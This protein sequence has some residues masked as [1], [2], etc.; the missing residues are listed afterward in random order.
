[1]YPI[2][3]HF[4]AAQMI[5]QIGLAFIV[6]IKGLPAERYI[7]YVMELTG[8]TA[9]A[10]MLPAVR[11]YRRDQT[12]RQAGG[13]APLQGRKQKLWEFLLLLVIGAGLSQY[14]NMILGMLRSFFVSSDYFDTMNAIIYG[15]DVWKQ[16]F[17]MGIV[18]PVAEEMIFRWLI[19]LRLRDYLRLPAA[20]LLSGALFGIYHGDVMQGLYAAILGAVFAWFLEAT[21]NLLSC[22]LLHIGANT[23]GIVF[24]AYGMSWLTIGNGQLLWIL[25]GI[26]LFSL[27]A[28]IPYFQRKYAGDRRRMV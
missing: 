12:A 28:G 26:L 13:L 20:M 16:V 10:V 23:W 3:I 7:H 19:F 5:S 15:K 9:L 2:G 17:W 4:L 21:G 18:A 11:L 14:A 1:M 22:V 27:L 8:I 6:Q 24:S 25:L